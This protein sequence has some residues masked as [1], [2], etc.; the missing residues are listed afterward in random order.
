MA[1]LSR[2][3]DNAS[4]LKFWPGIIFTAE[5]EEYINGLADIYSV[6][7]DSLAIVLI[8]CVAATLEFSFV[9]RANLYNMIVARSSYG[10]SELTKILRD[11]LKSVVLHRPGKFRP[12]SQA[13]LGQHINANLDEMSKVGLMA[14]L[15]DCCRTVICDEADMIFT[16]GGLFLSHNMCR[17]AAEMNCRAL[18]MT[19]FDRGSHAYIRQLANRSVSVKRFK[20]NILGCSTG[21]IISSIIIR[22][23]GGSCFDPAIGRFLF[24]PIDGSIIPDKLKQNQI[25]HYK[26]ASLEQY[27][28]ILSFI[29]NFIFAFEDDAI[30]E[31]VVWGNMCKQKSFDTRNTDEC[32]SARLDK[33]IQRAYRMVTFIQTIEIGF[34]IHQDYLNTYHQFPSAGVVDIHF[35]DHVESLFHLNYPDQFAPVDRQPFRIKKDVALRAI[36]LIACNM[37]QYAM[38]FDATNAPK[39]SSI[40]RQIIVVAPDQQQGLTHSPS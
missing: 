4:Q 17:T 22:M 40:G 16:D 35:V 14:G 23:K 15:D 37:R 18:V 13:A 5:L 38:L 6:H 32:L 30:H 31:M 12:N 11:M 28:I 20:L 26:M 10:K 3:I 27:V 39:F 19:L 7:A 21:D 36:D 1:Y 25:D 33:A 8:N 34:I 29:E 24:W 9:L 2:N